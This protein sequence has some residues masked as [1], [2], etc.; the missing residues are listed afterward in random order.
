MKELQQKLT[1]IVESL[2][3]K[4]RIVIGID[5]LSRAGKT[6]FV[7]NLSNELSKLGISYQVF[8]LDDFIVERN[9]RYNTGN[10]EWFEYYSLQWDVEFLRANLFERLHSSKSLLL[11]FY[12]PEK[13]QQILNEVILEGKS[14]LFIEGVFLLRE[15]WFSSLD[16]T[17]FLDCPRDLRFARES[18]LTQQDLE[19]F[20]QRYWKAE[21]YYLHNIKL[22]KKQISF[23]HQFPKKWETKLINTRTAEPGN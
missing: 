11:P 20:E 12:I 10:E 9:R 13:D 22:L 16:Y 6:T 7:N 3:L 5:G 19:K 1:S 2:D 4:E 8:H 14:V 23:I 17:V 15:E 21:D 18:V